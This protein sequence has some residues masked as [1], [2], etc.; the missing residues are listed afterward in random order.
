MI[1]D[2]GKRCQLPGLTDEEVTTHR[3]PPKTK[4]KKKKKKLTININKL[5]KYK[6]YKMN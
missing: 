1:Y 3:D 2:F 5:E 6:I 4:K